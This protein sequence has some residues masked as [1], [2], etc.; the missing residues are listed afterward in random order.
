MLVH[1]SKRELRTLCGALHELGYPWIS[2][3]IR[4]VRWIWG[5]NL[6]S[7]GLDRGKDWSGL[8]NEKTIILQNASFLCFIVGKD[9]IM[10]TLTRGIFIGTYFFRYI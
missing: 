4:G 7:V 6:E 3:D 2:M 5:Y 1:Y 9:R 10:E 8:R